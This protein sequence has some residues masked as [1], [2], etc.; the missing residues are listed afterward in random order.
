[1]SVVILHPFGGFAFLRQEIV[2]QVRSHVD[3]LVLAHA[4]VREFVVEGFR[5]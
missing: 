5:D 4:V 2:K 1:M 3:D